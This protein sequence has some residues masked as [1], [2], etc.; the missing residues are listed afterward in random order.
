MV[1][2]LVMML[3]EVEGDCWGVWYE[4]DLVISKGFEGRGEGMK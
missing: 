3:A 2:L 1:A 4:V